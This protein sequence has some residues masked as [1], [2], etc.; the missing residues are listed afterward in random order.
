[1]SEPMQLDDAAQVTLDSSGNGTV[2]LGPRRLTQIWNV[3]NIAVAVSTN[4]LEA[5]AT[6]YLGAVAAPNS[7]GGTYSGSGDANSTDVT[8]RAGQF[9]S[10]RWTGGDA[11]AVATLSVYG[12][13]T[14]G[15]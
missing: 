7:L 11:G 10:C 14:L 12:T 3:T 4:V 13:Y 6:T 15:R 2:K 9:I 5:T 1:M 8:L